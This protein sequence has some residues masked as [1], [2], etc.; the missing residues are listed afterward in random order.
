VGEGQDGGEGTC[1]MTHVVT[2]LP[3]SALAGEGWVEGAR[4]ALAQIPG[5]HAENLV[6]NCACSGKL[7]AMHS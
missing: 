5:M 1:C 2:Y 7:S 4:T 6:K 3:L